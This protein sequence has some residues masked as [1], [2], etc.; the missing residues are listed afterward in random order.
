M[1]P[2]LHRT[3]Q[4][5][6]AVLDHNSPRG[7]MLMYTA[8]SLTDLASMQTISIV[9]SFTNNTRRTTCRFRI[10]PC[11]ALT[12]PRGKFGDTF[13]SRLDPRR[14][15]YTIFDDKQEFEEYLL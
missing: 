11:G 12:V 13:L 2:R 4:E 7:D 6:A 1:H 3:Y 8:W 9:T 15:P 14:P 10:T 5:S